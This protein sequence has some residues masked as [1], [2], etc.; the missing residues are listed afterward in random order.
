[1]IWSFSDS[2]TFAKCQR[3]WYYDA[4]VAYWTQKDPR[5]WE[6]YLLSKLQTVSAWRGQVVD[7][8]VTTTLVPALNNRVAPDLNRCLGRARQLFD[9]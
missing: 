6:A 2:R 1:M 8:A 4:V 7:T 9:G 5:R 3:R